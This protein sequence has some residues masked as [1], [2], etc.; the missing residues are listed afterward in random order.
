MKYQ[1]THSD[2]ITSLLRSDGWRPRGVTSGVLHVC[3]CKPERLCSQ[4]AEL[5]AVEHYHPETIPAEAAS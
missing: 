3:G 2:S 5:R 4:H 1:A